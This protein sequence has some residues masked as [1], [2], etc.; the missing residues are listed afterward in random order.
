M[1]ARKSGLNPV[2]GVGLLLACGLPTVCASKDPSQIH[3]TEPTTAHCFLLFELG[4]GEIRR[5]P[6]EACG[7]RVSPASTFKVPH[8]LA[9]LDA[10]VIGGPSSRLKFDGIGKWP[11][12]SRRDHTLASAIRHSVVWYFQ[13]LAVRLGTQRERD[14]LQRFA[15]GN[16]DSSSGLTTFWL[17]GSLLISPDEQMAFLR[18]LYA[19][20]LPVRESALVALRKM[21]IQPRNVVVN[22]LGQQPF[23][24][25]WPDGTIVS[26][27]TGSTTDRSGRGVRWLIGRVR[28]VDR[29]FL[30]V[31]CVTGPADIDAMAAINL[32]ADALREEH[33]L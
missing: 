26:A 8:A 33:V 25:P 3:R 15:Y 30:F 27:T 20:N 10:G 19:G 29:A 22:A 32:A 31:S 14:Y 12:A 9:A 6:A 24:A 16:M 4:V 2:I 7:D 1:I 21:L 5:R 13:K 28:R 17:G 23:A 11:P 18:K